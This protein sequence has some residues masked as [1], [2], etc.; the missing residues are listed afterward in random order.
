MLP[1]LKKVEVDL[2]KIDQTFV[3]NVEPYNSS[4]VIVSNPQQLNYSMIVERIVLK[5]QDKRFLEKD[6]CSIQGNNVLS[7]LISA[8]PFINFYVKFTMGA[9]S[10]IA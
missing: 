8:I 4:H 3:Q 1:Y 5:K 2:L 9:S 7:N 6:Y 10:P